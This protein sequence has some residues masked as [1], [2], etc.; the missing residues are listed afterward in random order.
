MDDQGCM[1][2]YPGTPP[3]AHETIPQL[4]AHG[5]QFADKDG[6]SRWV[7][8]EGVWLLSTRPRLLHRFNLGPPPPL[9]QLLHAALVVVGR[10][11]GGGVREEFNGIPLHTI[12]ENNIDAIVGKR[13]TRKQSEH[14]EH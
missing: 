10:S 4:R 8:K 6:G 14:H 13:I 7:K 5:L 2:T 1:G 3:G 11:G 9:I 12:T